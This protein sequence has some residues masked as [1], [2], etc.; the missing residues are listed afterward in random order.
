MGGKKHEKLYPSKYK[1]VSC[2]FPVLQTKAFYTNTSAL[3]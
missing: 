2:V 3:F 1:L